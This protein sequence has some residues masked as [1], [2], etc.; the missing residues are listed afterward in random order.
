MS[1]FP[2]CWLHLGNY[3]QSN[4]RRVAQNNQSQRLIW[5]KMGV[6][7]RFYSHINKRTAFYRYFFYETYSRVQSRTLKEYYTVDQ[8]FCTW[9]LVAMCQ[10]LWIFWLDVEF[11]HDNS[12]VLGYGGLEDLSLLVIFGLKIYFNDFESALLFW[13]TF[14]GGFKRGLLFIS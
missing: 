10:F 9:Q 2:V 1:V 12:I 8:Q 11:C 13:K 4:R 6:R 3:F 5:N 14:S 7:F